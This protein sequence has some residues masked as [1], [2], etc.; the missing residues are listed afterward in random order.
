MKI[1]HRPKLTPRL[2]RGHKTGRKRAL[3]D[4]QVNYIR[5]TY[6][7]EHPASKSMQELADELGVH[8]TTIRQVVLRLGVYT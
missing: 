3:D 6:K 1:R 4:D 7:P 8:R 5:A 2:L